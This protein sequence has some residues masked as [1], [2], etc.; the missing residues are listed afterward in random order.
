MTRVILIFLPI[1]PRTSPAAP[2]LSDRP[3]VRSAA[4][5]AAEPHSEPRRH[6][7]SVPTISAERDAAERDAAERD[8]AEGD[9]DIG[10]KPS[11]Q[12]QRELAAL[13]ERIGDEAGRAKKRR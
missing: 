11:A 6:A 1:W 9:D 2:P 3:C 8:A 4:T 12:A 10:E 7:R 5:G 13:L